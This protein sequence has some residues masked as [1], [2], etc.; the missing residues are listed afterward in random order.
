VLSEALARR[1]ADVVGID[2]AEAS[3]AVAHAHAAAGI[4]SIDYRAVEIETLAANEAGSFDV[5]TCLEVVEHVPDPAGLV[6]AC[7][8][9]LRPGG[10]AFFSTINRN[11][12]SFLLGIVA[13]EYVLRLVP[14]GTHEYLK[15]VR[16][17]ELAGFCRAASLDARDTTGLH[18]H[19]VTGVHRH[20]GNADL[21]PFLQAEKPRTER[22]TR[23]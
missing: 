14:R 4:L 21:N 9:V 19:P 11:A 7:A 6:A 12:K 2:L 3:L 17:S 5:V 1:G 8:T 13:A 20:G 16:P 10:S 22:A 23:P 15:L 18:Y